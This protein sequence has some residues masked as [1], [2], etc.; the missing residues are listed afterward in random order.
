[1]YKTGD[2]NMQGGKNV[3]TP[4]DLNLR[5]YSGIWLQKTMKTS[6]RMASP[7]SVLNRKPSK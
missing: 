1:M 2:G 4:D 7:G 5:Y 3:S 6:V